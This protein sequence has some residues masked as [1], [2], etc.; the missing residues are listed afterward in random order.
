MNLLFYYLYI[1]RFWCDL[2]K[3]EWIFENKLGKDFYC[4]F[5]VSVHSLFG[6]F[7][8]QFPI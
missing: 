2:Y 8:A 6:L 3:Y 7:A 5:F 4:W 1:L